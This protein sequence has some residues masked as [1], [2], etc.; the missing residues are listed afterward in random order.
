[1]VLVPCIADILKCIRILREVK[2]SPIPSISEYVTLIDYQSKQ[3]ES[4]LITVCPM[5][6]FSLK[7]SV[8]FTDCEYCYTVAKCNLK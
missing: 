4:L 6:P 2:M 5:R 7:L 8:I 1:M 3:N